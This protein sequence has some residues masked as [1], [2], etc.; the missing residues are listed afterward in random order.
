MFLILCKDNIGGKTIGVPWQFL[1]EGLD[2]GVT[3]NFKDAL[4]KLEGLGYK[5]K[6][7][8]LKL[9]KYS[10]PVYYIIMP[11][12]SS[13]NLARF[14]GVRFGKRVN[15]DNLLQTYMNSRAQFGPEVRRR[16][17][18]G[19]YVLSAGYYDA[20]Y[21]K[22][23]SVRE[24]I[25]NE[26]N[27]VFKDVDVIATPTAPTPA[28]KIGEK[29]SDPLSMYLEDIFTTPANIAGIPAL[30]VPMGDVSVDGKQLPV[31]IQV[32]AREGGES[33]LFKIGKEFLEEVQ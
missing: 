32:M 5:V 18:L 6:E 11:A 8:E 4:K 27:E 21:Y 2:E 7:V 13:T 19:T 24:A 25:K 16:I 10:L 22:A 9:V 1:K 28:F 12:E 26:F 15:G 14:D 17:L 30:S 20:Y 33:T 3:N 29:T 31:G 23:V